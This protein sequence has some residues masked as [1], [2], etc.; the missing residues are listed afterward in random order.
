MKVRMKQ[1]CVTEFLHALQNLLK[2]VQHGNEMGYS[3]LE[4]VKNH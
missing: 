3:E 4:R 2:I 1:R